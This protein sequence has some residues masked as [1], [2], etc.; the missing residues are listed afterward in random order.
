MSSPEFGAVRCSTLG[1]TGLGV[2]IHLV[3]GL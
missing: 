2:D 1:G 3:A